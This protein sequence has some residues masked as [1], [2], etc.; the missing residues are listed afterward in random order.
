[1]QVG[2]H[3]QCPLSGHHLHLP[4]GR[5]SRLDHLVMHISDK[6][7]EPYEPV[8]ETAKIECLKKKQWCTWKLFTPVSTVSFTQKSE[9]AT[10]PR[11]NGFQADCKNVRRQEENTAGFRSSRYLWLGRHSPQSPHVLMVLD[12]LLPLWKTLHFVWNTPS[13]SSD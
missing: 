11:I 10:F 12:S 6:H 4:K 3:S 5:T 7:L 2:A 8:S 13:Y 9:A 1:M